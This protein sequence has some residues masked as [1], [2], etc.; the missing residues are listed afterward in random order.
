MP[1]LS[2]WEQLPRT[3]AWLKQHHQSLGSPPI[4]VL[5]TGNHAV[6]FLPAPD[7]HDPRHLEYER[8]IRLAQARVLKPSV[9]MQSKSSF[10]TA[11]NM[12][13]S[14]LRTQSSTPS[15]RCTPRASKAVPV[16]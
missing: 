16:D 2:E 3:E 7:A 8:K 1:P 13:N 10:P 11:R 12:S 9:P 6:H 4:R 14:M 15:V 5:T